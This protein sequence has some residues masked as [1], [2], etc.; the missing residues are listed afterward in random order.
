MAG[1]GHHS[2]DGYRGIGNCQTNNLVRLL[3][4]ARWNPD[5][6]YNL[7]CDDLTEVGKLILVILDHTNT[8]SFMQDG[9][10]FTKNDIL[11]FANSSYK[12]TIYFYCPKGHETSKQ[13]L[14]DGKNDC[15]T[16]I[17]LNY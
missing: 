13:Y 15:L 12:K 10:E 7:S 4:S 3:F 9:M 2:K 11:H 8:Q 14:T 16:Y 1:S 6:V 17:N 5:A